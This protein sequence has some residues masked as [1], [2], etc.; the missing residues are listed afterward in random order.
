MSEERYRC[1]RCTMSFR[2]GAAPVRAERLRCPDCKC[3]FWSVSGDGHGPVVCGME[4][5]ERSAA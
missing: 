2:I 5:A 3:D 1:A 4:P